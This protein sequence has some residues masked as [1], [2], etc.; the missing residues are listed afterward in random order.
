MA[1][2]E[3]VEDF[4]EVDETI[5]G[6]RYVLLSF[7][8]PEKVLPK[9]EVFKASKFLHYIFNDKDRRVQDIRNKME[10]S[11]NI[12]YEYVNE[13][14]EDWRLN[15][16][17]ELENEFHEMNDFMTTKRCVKIRGT[18]DLR[19]HAE[20][21]AKLLNKKDPIHHIYIGEVG[22]WLEWDP[23]C[24]DIENQEYQEGE[25]NNLMKKYKENVENR[26]V[27]YEELKKERIAKAREEVRKKK[28]LAKKTAVKIDTES[29][30]KNKIGNLK[31]MLNEIDE[32]LYETEQKKFRM[33]KEQDIKI[34]ELEDKEE[35]KPI[36]NFKSSN[37]SELEKDDPWLQRKKEQ[38]EQ[39]EQAKKSN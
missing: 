12:T 21:K 18:Y 16:N 33:T 19:R 26:D 6:Q 38:A 22:K 36:N 25:L 2:T 24:Q 3:I 35:T 15:R 8:S 28:E 5:P 34:K 4:L 14:Y 39:A 29:V 32:N 10:E 1:D 13:L 31:T 11:R 17:E 23:S 20:K 37:M 7:V 9:K 30:A 27:L